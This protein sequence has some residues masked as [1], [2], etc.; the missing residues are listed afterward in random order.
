LIATKLGLISRHM[1]QAFDRRLAGA[2]RAKWTAILAVAESPG[3]T[4]RLIATALQVT[5]VTA[6][7]LIDRLCSDGLMVREEHPNDRRAYRVYL[8]EAAAPLL[9]QM[10]KNASLGEAEAFAGFS[11]QEVTRLLNYVER[12][13]VNLLRANARAKGPPTVLEE[14]DVLVR[15]A[16]KVKPAR[17]ADLTAESPFQGRAPNKRRSVS[18]PDPVAAANS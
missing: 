13:Q 18:L 1:R 8:T 12:I 17:V 14:H 7:R 10:D 6:G 4:Q 16:K 3:A 11:E 2:T 5:Q 15:T 9:E